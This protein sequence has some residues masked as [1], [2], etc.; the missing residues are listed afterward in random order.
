[1]ELQLA[2]LTKL[3]RE[4]GAKQRK[5]AAAAKARERKM[6]AEA[7]ARERAAA[8]LKRENAASEVECV[9]KIFAMARKQIKPTVARTSVS[10]KGSTCI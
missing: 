9:S 5:L 7:K 4:A 2:T 10:P 3:Q 1:V 6:R 8:K